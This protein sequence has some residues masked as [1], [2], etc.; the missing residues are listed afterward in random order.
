MSASLRLPSY[1]VA[2]AAARAEWGMAVV[3]QIRRLSRTTVKPTVP[4]LRKAAPTVALTWSIDGLAATLSAGLLLMRGNLIE[5]PEQ[6]ITLSGTP[7]YTWLQFTISPATTPTPSL[8]Q[9]SAWPSLDLGIY[10][11]F[12]LAVFTVVT[13][14]VATT[15]LYHPG[16]NAIYAVD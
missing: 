1:P 8:Q 13:G 4:A 7:V 9:G 5:V 14:A 16:G 12:P 2:G 15:Y 10:G 6:T 11:Y 3:D